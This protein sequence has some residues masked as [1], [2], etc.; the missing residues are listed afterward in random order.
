MTRDYVRLL[1]DSDVPPPFHVRLVRYLVEGRQPDLFLLA[2]LVNDLDGA[3]LCADDESAAA[4]VPLVRW[5]R[6][7]APSPAW[8][9]PLNVDAWIADH[10]SP[11]SH[12]SRP[13]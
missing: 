5:L 13:S 3:V 10:Q 12:G 9:S 4:L 7:Y 8:R 2:V 11:L 6:R 1:R